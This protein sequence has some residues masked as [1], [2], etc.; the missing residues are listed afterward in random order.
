MC[1]MTV[2][3]TSLLQI[4]YSCWLAFELFFCYT[5]IIE[6]KGLS[7]E[8]TAALFDGADVVDQIHTRGRPTITNEKDAKEYV[9]EN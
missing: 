4:V 2:L 6:T 3:L 7:L 1:C 9:S 5:F 8:E